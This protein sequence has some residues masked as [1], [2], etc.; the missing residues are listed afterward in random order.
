MALRL[1]RVQIRWPIIQPLT[2]FDVES[3]E[4]EMEITEETDISGVEAKILMDN[5]IISQELAKLFCQRCIFVRIDP[6]DKRCSDSPI[7]E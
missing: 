4:S 5:F 3:L 1:A 2:T 6:S 7:Q